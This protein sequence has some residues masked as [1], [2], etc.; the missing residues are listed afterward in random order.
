MLS[1]RL[2][3]PRLSYLL[4]PKVSDFTHSNHSYGIFNRMNQTLPPGIGGSSSRGG[5]HQQ[6]NYHQPA[7][8]QQQHA[9]GWRP[10]GNSGPAAWRSQGPGNGK[11]HGIMRRKG[12]LDP[13]N[14]RVKIDD[15][16]L[17]HPKMRAI[18]REKLPPKSNGKCLVMWDFGGVGDVVLWTARNECFMATSR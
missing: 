16:I 3:F 1:P 9:G 17:N 11:V 6:V 5:S 15:S 8:G 14:W 10:K 2:H 7:G 12:E 18:D 4:C 13:G